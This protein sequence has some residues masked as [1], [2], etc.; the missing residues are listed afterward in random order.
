MLV[1]EDGLV[2]KE[3]YTSREFLDLEME[4]LWTRVWQ[5]ACREEELAGTGDFVEYTIGDQ[6]ILVVRVS[7]DQ[8]KAY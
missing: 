7:P 5:V 6:S 4:R 3:R 1:G 2:P 8:V